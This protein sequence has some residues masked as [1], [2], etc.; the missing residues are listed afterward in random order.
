MVMGVLLWLGSAFVWPSTVGVHGI[1]QAV[2]LAALIGGGAAIYVAALVLLGVIT[3][4][5]I[6][7]VFKRARPD[8]LRA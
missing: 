8:D 4:A 6:A 7:D 1:A 3:R 5:G 2:I